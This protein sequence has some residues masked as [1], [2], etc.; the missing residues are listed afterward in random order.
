[1]SEIRI[2]SPVAS[3]VRIGQCGAFDQR[4]KTRSIEMLLVC[5]QTNF[6]VAQAFTVGKLSKRH[7]QK[8]F[9]AREPANAFI[10]IVTSYTGVEI[11][12]RNELQNLA[13]DCLFLAHALPPSSICRRIKRT[14]SEIFQ[15][16]DNQFYSL[17][18]VGNT[19]IDSCGETNRTAVIADHQSGTSLCIQRYR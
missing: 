15:I 8:L 18:I 17:R 11:V 1:M 10:A 9:P 12:V 13:E 5:G 19:L 3:V 7:R 2:N 6:N 16:R 14:S 4:T